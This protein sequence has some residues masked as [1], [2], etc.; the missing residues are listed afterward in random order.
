MP[1]LS[2]SPVS[3]EAPERII[4]RLGVVMLSTSCARAEEPSS[5]P[6]RLVTQTSALAPLRDQRPRKRPKPV[7][8]LREVMSS[9]L[10]SVR[11]SS[12]RRTC[13]GISGAKTMAVRSPTCTLTSMGK[14][15]MSA[16]QSGIRAV[17]TLGKPRCEELRRQD[18]RESSERVRTSSRLAGAR[19]YLVFI[20]VIY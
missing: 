15:T 5:S 18:E 14:S 6:R 1:A 16:S 3:V 10:P 8:S 20:A 11:S 4:L 2:R 17:S 13:S 7:C 12:S 19:E 9:A